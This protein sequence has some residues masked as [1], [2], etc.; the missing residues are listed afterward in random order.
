MAASHFAAVAGAGYVPASLLCSAYWDRP[1][2][3]CFEALLG[4]CVTSGGLSSP[5]GQ[6]FVQ[7]GCFLQPSISLAE[8]SR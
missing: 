6:G 2:E 7:H 8:Q 3:K 4:V 5:Q 1:L